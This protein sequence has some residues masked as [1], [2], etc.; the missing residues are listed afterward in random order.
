MIAVVKAGL[1]KDIWTL[2]DYEITYFLKV[3]RISFSDYV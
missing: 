2:H 3:S 1:G